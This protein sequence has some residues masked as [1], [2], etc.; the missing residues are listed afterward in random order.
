[1]D[2]TADEALLREF[3]QGKTAVAEATDADE[4]FHDSVDSVMELDGVKA[5]GS[6]ETT[7]PTPT[8][9][10]GG[11]QTGEP[12]D[13]KAGASGEAKVDED[14]L[15]DLDWQVAGPKRKKRADMTAEERK[16]DNE[17]KKV[18]QIKTIQSD[19]M[20]SEYVKFIIS[21]YLN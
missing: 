6:G 3:E 16:E 11:E 7:T 19:S 1:M 4:E 17:R 13:A 21:T 8:G 2:T 20:A 15:E 18:C 12:G 5:G 10:S 9:A 14:G